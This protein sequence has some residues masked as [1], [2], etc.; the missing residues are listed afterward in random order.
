MTL[1]EEAKQIYFGDVKNATYQENFEAAVEKLPVV[2]KREE[3]F[4]CSECRDFTKTKQMG[5]GVKAIYKFEQELSLRKAKA[6]WI[7]QSH[8][9]GCR[10]WD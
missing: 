4:Y 2:D 10:G 1:K 5:W 7:V 6:I 9:D 8:Y 3:G